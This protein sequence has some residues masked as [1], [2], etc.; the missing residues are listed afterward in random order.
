VL[1]SSK[2][3]PQHADDVELT[4]TVT[5]ISGA[6]VHYDQN[7]VQFF[8]INPPRGEGRGRWE[9]DDCANLPADRQKPA[10]TLNAG[11]SLTLK[12]LYPGNKDVTT[13]EKCRKLEVGEYEVNAL[14]LVCEG[15]SYVD[16]YCNFE[17]DVQYKAAPVRI[18]VES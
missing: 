14:V 7:Q 6:S 2:L 17:K 8:S 18:T 10:A 5:N 3:C 1:T 12:A 16:G 9:D 4:M 15:D 13:R 11:Q